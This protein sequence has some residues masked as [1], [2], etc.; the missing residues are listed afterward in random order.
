MVEHANLRLAVIETMLKTEMICLQTKNGIKYIV[1]SVLCVICY[2][3]TILADIVFD[4]TEAILNNK[5]V[6]TNTPLSEV[7]TNDFWGTKIS[8]SRSHK[9]Y[10]PLTVIVFRLIRQLDGF[11]KSKLELKDSD[12]SPS[13]YHLF[14]IMCYIVTNIL[15]FKVLTKLLNIFSSNTCNSNESNQRNAFLTTILFTCH[16]IHCEVVSLTI[17]PYLIEV[18]QQF[19][20]LR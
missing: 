15:L 17:D 7:F 18:S 10:R 13:L 16:P 12:L 5:D 1:I 19:Y 9:S 6:M 4:D 20:L 14:N 3:R 2:W 8:D 11:I